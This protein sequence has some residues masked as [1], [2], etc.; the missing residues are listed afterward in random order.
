VR[1]SL[2][3]QVARMGGEYDHWSNLPNN[4]GGGGGGG[5]GEKKTG[6]VRGEVKG[7]G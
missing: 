4:T 2:G 5:G 7:G 1:W 3:K 6:G